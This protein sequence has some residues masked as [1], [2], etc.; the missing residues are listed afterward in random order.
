MLVIAFRNDLT[1]HAKTMYFGR[2]MAVC[3]H[4][5]HTNAIFD[6][7][8]LLLKLLIFLTKTENIFK[9]LCPLWTQSSIM[10]S[11]TQIY[12]TLFL[13]LSHKSQC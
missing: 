5:R 8:C 7:D 9:V 6:F 10:I 1:L 11:G 12:F 4:K 2:Q 13:A 3:V